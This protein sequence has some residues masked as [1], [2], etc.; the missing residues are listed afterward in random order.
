MVVALISFLDT[1]PRT[2][3]KARLP[4]AMWAQASWRG[5]ISLDL[6]YYL[7]YVLNNPPEANGIWTNT[8]ANNQTCLTSEWILTLELPFL[9]PNSAGPLES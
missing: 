9:V 5:Q 1:Q 2:E 8:Q 6:L 7:L 4:A 3:R